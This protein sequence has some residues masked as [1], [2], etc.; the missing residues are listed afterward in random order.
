MNPLLMLLG[1]ILG[2]S[3]LAMPL[4]RRMRAA[5]ASR[6]HMET[7]LRLLDQPAEALPLQRM[8]RPRTELSSTAPRALRVAFARADISL[9]PGVIV[10]VASAVAGLCAAGWA[11]AG[12]RAGLLG[13]GVALLALAIAFRRISASRLAVFVAGLPNFLDATRQ[14]LLVGNSFQQALVKAGHDAPPG[15]QRYLEPMLRRLQHGAPVDDSLAWLAERIDVNELHMFAAAV[16]TNL[17]YGGRL[18]TVLA[19]LVQILRDRARVGREL[20]AATAEIRMSAV[21]LSCLPL[22]V[23]GFI[24][25]S[26]PVY[27]RFFIDT[28]EGHTQLMIAAGLEIS[29][30]LVMRR[31]MRLDF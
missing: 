23:A 28:P 9:S 29:G 27:M 19:N 1:G 30:V 15:V 18:A 26:S 20:R 12:W 10:P 6:Q 4:L 16:Q 11:A 3:I 2:L 24:T 5:S 25:F 7:R 13:L 17:R 8:A 14:M 21:V 22:A 31:M